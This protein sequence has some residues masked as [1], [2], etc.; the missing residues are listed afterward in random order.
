MQIHF[1]GPGGASRA[2]KLQS[3]RTR[4]LPHWGSLS[5]CRFQSWEADAHVSEVAHQ[6]QLARQATYRCFEKFREENLQE[7]ERRS[8][9]RADEGN[10]LLLPLLEPIL[11]WR[12][13]LLSWVGMLKPLFIAYSLPNQAWRLTWEGNQKKQGA[14]HGGNYY[15]RWWPCELWWQLV[16]GR[17]R[18]ALTASVSKLRLSF[19]ICWHSSFQ[20]QVQHRL[21]IRTPQ[22]S[23]RLHW[24]QAENGISPSCLIK[25]TI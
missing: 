17:F 10:H 2:T 16:Q 3:S 23:G 22:P 25:G 15:S 4:L 12:L 19:Q 13:R 6:M 14:C 21:S 18:S 7:G 9:G 8:K 24:T 20:T 5:N 1:T 11:E